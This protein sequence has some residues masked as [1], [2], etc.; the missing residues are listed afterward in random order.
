MAVAG[1]DSGVDAFAL[2]EAKCF[3]GAVDVFFHGAG[4]GADGGPGDGFGDFDDGIEV[5]GAGDGEAGFDDIDA[6]AFQLLGDLN[7]L[8]RVELASGHLFAVA[9]GGVKNVKSFAHGRTV[10]WKGCAK[11]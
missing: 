9:E 2:G 11:K 6:E 1:S 7:L 5:A 10:W 3:C 4:E 8:N